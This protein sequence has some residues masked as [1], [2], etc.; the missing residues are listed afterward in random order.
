MVAV[1]VAFGVMGTLQLVAVGTMAN[2]DAS[3][4]T[5]ASHLAGNVRE[6]MLDVRFKESPSTS[7][8]GAEPDETAVAHYDDVDDFDGKTFSPPL[9]VRREP[10]LNYTGWSQSIQ[11]DSVDEDVVTTTRGKDNVTRPM[12]R[13]VVRV[14]HHSALVHEASWLVANV[15]PTQ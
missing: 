14:S 11:I 5:T 9:D 12:C 13:V 7:T 3:K 15:T 8:W 1:I 10:L 6:M 2:I 4:L